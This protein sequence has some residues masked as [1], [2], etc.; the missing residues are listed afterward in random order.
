[1]CATN[2]TRNTKPGSVSRAKS[3]SMSSANQDHRIQPSRSIFARSVLKSKSRNPKIRGPK[4]TL[5]QTLRLLPSQFSKRS[6]RSQKLEPG[7]NRS[8]PNNP[9][10]TNC[11]PNNS[12]SDKGFYNSLRK[13]TLSTS[14]RRS[15]CSTQS[16][17]SCSKSTR[18]YFLHPSK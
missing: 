11:L 9:L 12:V 5:N 14:L 4:L 16:R 2:T 17:T 10:L 18:R 15:K 8:F 13:I 7:K 1:M 6:V 3:G